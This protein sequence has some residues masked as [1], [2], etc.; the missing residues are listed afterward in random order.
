MGVN[1]EDFR[2]GKSDLFLVRFG[3]LLHRLCMSLLEA[4]VMA[5]QY[6]RLF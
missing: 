4:N 2:N 3:E 1:D 5:D 6:L